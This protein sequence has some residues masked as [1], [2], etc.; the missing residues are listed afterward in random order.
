ML[1]HPSLPL[2]VALT[3]TDTNTNID[4]NTIFNTITNINTNTNPV[5]VCQPQGVLS[6]Q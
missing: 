2:L 4:K 5:G 1:P 6:L 3:D